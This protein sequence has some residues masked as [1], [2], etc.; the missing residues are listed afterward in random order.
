[1]CIVIVRLNVLCCNAEGNTWCNTFY[2]S[3][4]CCIIYPECIMG[5]MKMGNIVP[6]T[7]INPTSLAL[8]ASVLPSQHVGYLMS[9]LFQGP[10]VYAVPCL[11]GQCRLLHSSPWNCKSFNAYK[12][13]HTGNELSYKY[14]G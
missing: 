13:I 2:L 7:G 5:K 11:T 3:R 14:T 6:S 9:P 8:W 1:M 12:Y 4:V 10:H